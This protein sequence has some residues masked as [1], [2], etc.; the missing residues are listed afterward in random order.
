MPRGRPAQTNP[1]D[2]ALRDVHPSREGVRGQHVAIALLLSAL[3]A[4][5]MY[6]RVIPHRPPT[7]IDL[8]RAT[9]EQI[10][11]LP[12]LSEADAERIVGNRPYATKDDLVRRG[13]LTEE[14]FEAIQDRVYLS[15]PSADTAK[16]RA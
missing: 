3:T 12:G 6:G 8:N 10:A 1:P 15:Q 9:A 11:G 13:V 4:C 5:S 14:R 7:G 16:P 2:V